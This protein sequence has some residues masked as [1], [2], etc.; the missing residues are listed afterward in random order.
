MTP[1]RIA[2]HFFTAIRIRVNSVSFLI[3]SI[4]HV[5]YCVVTWNKHYFT[6]LL[7]YYNTPCQALQNCML[8]ISTLHAMHYVQHHVICITCGH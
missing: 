7:F 6:F 8:R 4:Q 2:M 5:P 1:S 3:L